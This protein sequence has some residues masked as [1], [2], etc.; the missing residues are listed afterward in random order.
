MK[1]IFIV[2]EYMIHKLYINA[3]DNKQPQSDECVC[4]CV[5][6]KSLS[7]VQLFA[8]WTTVQQIPVSM[9][10]SGQEYENRLPFP[11]PHDLPDLGIEPMFL[12]W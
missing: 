3:T 9:G 4:V 6:S 8:S 5:C 2:G 11:T 1:C 10:L 7:H 12:H